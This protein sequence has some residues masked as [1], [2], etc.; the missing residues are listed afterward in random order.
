M[1]GITAREWVVETPTASGMTFLLP[2]GNEGKSVID[3]LTHS[4][5]PQIIDNLSTVRQD[6]NDIG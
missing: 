6:G 4:Q 1:G 5:D 2:C 3:Y